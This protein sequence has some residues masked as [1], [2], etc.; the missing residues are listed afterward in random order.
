[1]PATKDRQIL[2]A[3]T[4]PL[5]YHVTLE[6]NFSTFKY[7]GSVVIDLA[8]VEDTNSISLNTL[9]LEILS[10]KVISGSDTLI[11]SVSHVVTEISLHASIADWANWP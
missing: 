11:R 2:P 3:H 10:T 1:M 5:H 7:R 4:K 9:E 8:V 6:P